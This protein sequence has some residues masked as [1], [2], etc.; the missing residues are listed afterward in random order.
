[1][2]LGQYHCADKIPHVSSLLI[3]PF[4]HYIKRA[5]YKAAISWAFSDCSEVDCLPLCI[6]D[7]V[8][9]KSIEV[10]GESAT[11]TL[12]DTWDAEVRGE[13]GAKMHQINLLTYKDITY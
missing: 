10:D 4:T 6:S 1:M 2:Y 5:A 12:F 8:C 9:E 7:E 3:C 13:T 11:I